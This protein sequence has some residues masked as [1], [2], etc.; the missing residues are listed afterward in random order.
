M[1]DFL[2]TFF[3]IFRLTNAYC[4]VVRYMDEQ[5]YYLDQCSS[6]WSIGT[7]K[8][9]MGLDEYTLGFTR[10][11]KRQCQHFQKCIAVKVRAIF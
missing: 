10:T 11:I 6:K 1:L 4:L 8:G 5:I 3:E 7:S 2:L 9:Q